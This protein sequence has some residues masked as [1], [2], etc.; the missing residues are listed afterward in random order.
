[1]S[2]AAKPPVDS[3]GEPPTIGLPE[4][5]DHEPTDLVIAM[6]PRQIIGGFAV[7]AA[8]VTFLVGRRRRR[9][10]RRDA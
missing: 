5:L 9:R 7:L 4:R 3:S 1:M 2:P 10:L 6:S 8:I